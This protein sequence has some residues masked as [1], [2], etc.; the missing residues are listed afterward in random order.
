MTKPILIVASLFML[1]VTTLAYANPPEDRRVKMR[2]EYR[3]QETPDHVAFMVVLYSIKA[4]DDDDHDSMLEVVQRSMHLPSQKE[5]AAFLEKVQA[6]AKDLQWEIVKLERETVCSPD[7][8]RSKK[9]IYKTFDRLEDLREVKYHNAYTKFMSEL[10]DQELASFAAWLDHRRSRV[11]YYVTDKESA[12]ESSGRDV[13][14]F[15]ELWCADLG[16][17]TREDIK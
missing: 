1:T 17:R 3:G 14:S 12:W 13:E 8:A 15:V 10:N 5:T 11:S 2:R 16:R 6:A 7:S 9:G 4:A